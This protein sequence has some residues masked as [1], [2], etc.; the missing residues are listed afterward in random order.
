[1]R[2]LN[3]LAA[4]GLILPLLLYTATSTRTQQWEPPA[5]TDQ[6]AA[7]DERGELTKKQYLYNKATSRWEDNTSG[8]NTIALYIPKV[9]DEYYRRIPYDKVVFCDVE[10]AETT[11]V[12]RWIGSHRAL[13]HRIDLFRRK[14]LNSPLK[15]V[16]TVFASYPVE[17]PGVVEFRCNSDGPPVRAVITA[18]AGAPFQPISICDEYSGAGVVKLQSGAQYVIVVECL[19][20]R[21][22]RCKAE[23]AAHSGGVFES[24]YDKRFIFSSSFGR[25]IRFTVDAAP[26]LPERLTPDEVKRRVADAVSRAAS[27]RA[28]L[29][30]RIPL[31]P[32]VDSRTWACN[33]VDLAALKQ[34]QSELDKVDRLPLQDL[35]RLERQLSS[36]IARLA[37]VRD[38]KAA[39]ANERDINAE[40]ARLLKN[41]LLELI[42]PELTRMRLD[43]QRVDELRQNIS[44][45]LRACGR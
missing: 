33:E 8:A 31:H 45:A 5:P 18:A 25:S 36:E 10:Y 2:P 11:D 35:E 12:K 17:T 30:R 32:R 44:G 24:P 21:D 9:M 22:T 37:A 6:L 39:R 7:Y 38:S 27:V 40:F 16:C 43:Y 19:A 29:D 13:N 34:S 26:A 41:A 23:I 1:M 3:K 14:D 15:K 42:V 20:T 4:C 28:L